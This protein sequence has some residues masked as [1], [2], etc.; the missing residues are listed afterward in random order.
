MR[1]APVLISLALAA[2]VVCANAEVVTAAPTADDLV[3]HNLLRLLE[4][5]GPFVA[6]VAAVAVAYGKIL[7]KLT[8]LDRKVDAVKADL[9]RRAEDLQ[10]Q[11]DG[12]EEEKVDFR[13][14]EACHKAILETMKSLDDRLR[15]IQRSLLNVRVGAPAAAAGR[16]D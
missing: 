9:E 2:G 4:V 11:V 3:A 16:A 6:F 5:F 15:D 14:H 13:V 10:A 1:P 7:A 12:L 8:A